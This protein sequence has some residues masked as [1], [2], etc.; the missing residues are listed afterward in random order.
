M[1]PWPP[2][3][4]EV[5]ELLGGFG[6][7]FMASSPHGK[8][9]QNQLHTVTDLGL[10]ENFLL[11]WR[12]AVES[13]CCWSMTVVI[14]SIHH[15]RNF[16]Q[17]T[18]TNV[19][20]SFFP[21]FVYSYLQRLPQL[22]WLDLANSSIERSNCSCPVIPH[23]MSRTILFFLFQSSKNSI[24]LKIRSLHQ[25]LQSD[26]RSPACDYEPSQLDAWQTTR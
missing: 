9:I 6:V 10:I 5:F 17:L 3:G 8:D 7:S 26:K 16:F 15:E 12:F 24:W 4:Q 11:N 21:R 13:F 2:S 1:I 22:S 14:S 19:V 18:R 23:Q 20:W 25:T